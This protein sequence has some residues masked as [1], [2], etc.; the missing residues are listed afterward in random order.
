MWVSRQFSCDWKSRIL[1]L[2]LLN[3]QLWL[4]LQINSECCW[5][6]RIRSFF[7]ILVAL[8]SP[9]FSLLSFWCYA[10]SRNL[11]QI[12]VYQVFFFFFFFFFFCRIETSLQCNG[13]FGSQLVLDERRMYQESHRDRLH[14]VCCFRF[15]FD[16]PSHFT[17]VV[18]C[19]FLSVSNVNRRSFVT[20]DVL[21]SAKCIRHWTN[22]TW[23]ECLSCWHRFTSCGGIFE[24]GFCSHRL[25]EGDRWSQ[26]I[27]LPRLN[28]FDV[29]CE[30]TYFQNAHQ[31]STTE[32]IFF[33][34]A[35]SLEKNPQKHR[36]SCTNTAQI[37]EIYF[38]CVFFS[39]R[40]QKVQLH[41]QVC[42]L[43]PNRSFLG[44]WFP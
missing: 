30:C 37:T 19:T 22:R 21:E 39:N 29:F 2:V 32:F 42:C 25:G 24:S 13:K 35:L 9:L 14:D 8:E 20:R 36:N 16:F 18:E 10:S 3:P 43:I 1:T 17:G 33:C 5:V 41:C 44:D 31:L 28:C 11:P 40:N 27:M 4:L 23:F 7:F 34:S 15:A 38:C 12:L 6:V 26:T